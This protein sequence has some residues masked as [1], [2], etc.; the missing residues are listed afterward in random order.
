MKAAIELA[1]AIETFLDGSGGPYDWD[2]ALQG[3]ELKDVKDF[4]VSIQLLYPSV[5]RGSYTSD[6]G[7]KVLSRLAIELRNGSQAAKTYIESCE[8]EAKRAG[9]LD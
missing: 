8:N 7:E 4:C 6:E 9:G 3:E 1:L 2:D 5:E